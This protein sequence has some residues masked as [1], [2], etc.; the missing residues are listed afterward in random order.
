MK[1]QIIQ[2]HKGATTGVFIP[3]KDWEKLKKK[4]SIEENQVLFELSNEQKKSLDAQNNLT[5][6]DFQ[7]NDE[8]VAELKIEYG[9]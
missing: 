6:S 9:L 1:T 5:I 8:F 7:K 2:D 4:Y 3:I